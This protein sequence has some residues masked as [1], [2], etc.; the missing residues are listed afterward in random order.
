MLKGSLTSL[1][2]LFS[3]LSFSQVERK[4]NGTN[5]ADS[6]YRPS[7]SQQADNKREMMKQL[8][9]TREQKAKMKEIHQ[10]M[11]AKK[12]AISNDSKLSAEEKQTQLRNL[13]KE[14]F[15]NT[16]NILNDDQKQKLKTMRDE[17]RLGKQ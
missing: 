7:S 14:L 5:A 1:F 6:G 8:N 13:Q 2:L 11:Q 16:L 12:D 15:Q 9:L 10:T 4:I 17:K 3:F